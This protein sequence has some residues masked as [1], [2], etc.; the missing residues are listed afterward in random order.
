MQRWLCSAACLCG[1]ATAQ[2]LPAPSAPEGEVAAAVSDQRLDAVRGG[3]DAGNGLLLS[4]GIE[5]SVSINGTTAATSG[6]QVDDVT[7]L[8]PA[9]AHALGVAA[10]ALT[11][12]QSGPANTFQPGASAMAPGGIFIQNGVNGQLIQSQTTI[13]AAV[14]SAALLKA[15]NFGTSMRDALNYAAGPR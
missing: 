1:A 7:K 3:F 15:L 14:N 10:S 13:N 11:L 2:N 5:R 12:V 8:S 4:L 9:Q 6:F